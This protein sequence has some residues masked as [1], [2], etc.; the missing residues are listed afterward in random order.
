MP[1]DHPDATLFALAEDC[2]AAAA[3]AHEKAMTHLNLVE[4][5]YEPVPMPDTILKT[6]RDAELGLYLG[7]GGWTYGESE[8]A[9]IRADSDEAGHAF[10]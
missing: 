1:A 8:I 10:Q 9:A 7:S 5:E 2:A 4:A 6:A 3:S